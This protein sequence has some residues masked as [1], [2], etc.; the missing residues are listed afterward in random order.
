MD[1]VIDAP[2]DNDGFSVKPPMPGGRLVPASHWRTLDTVALAR[3]LLGKVLAVRLENGT[4]YRTRVRETE[5]YHGPDDRASH[6]SR[7]RTPRN[8]PMFVEGGIWYVYL[9]KY[10]PYSIC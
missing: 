3:D 10:L 9:C 8:A 5:A 1:A 7:G 2:C 4:V 6:A